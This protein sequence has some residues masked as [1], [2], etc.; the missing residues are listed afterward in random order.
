MR[1]GETKGLRVVAVTRFDAGALRLAP[2]VVTR[3]SLV[4]SSNSPYSLL[5]SVPFEGHPSVDLHVLAAPNMPKP[6]LP[7]ST[8]S[9]EGHSWRPC[10]FPWPF[11]AVRRSQDPSQCNCVLRGVTVN[12]VAALGFGRP[13]GGEGP[14][15]GA[16]VSPS[17]L[18]L[19]MLTND[20]DLEKGE[21][22][23]VFWPPRPGSG[24][25]VA[26][27]KPRTWREQLDHSKGVGGPAA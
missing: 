6:L 19:E 14:P 5:I 11:W 27:P 24:R 8:P 12:V 7:C 2:L 17:E 20:R 21:E 16:A 22:L 18:V 4:R 1:G 26:T 13:A 25:Q 23:V 9:V 10:N 15:G 3:H